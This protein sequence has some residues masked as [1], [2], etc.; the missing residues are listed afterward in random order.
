M[1]GRHTFPDVE[2]VG[3]LA[4]VLRLPAV[5]RVR[6]SG[7]KVRWSPKD[8]PPGDP[9]PPRL[10]FTREPMAVA[11]EVVPIE[12]RDGVSRAR[13]LHTIRKFIPSRVRSPQS[14]CGPRPVPLQLTAVWIRLR[15]HNCE[16]EEVLGSVTSSHPDGSDQA[17]N[18]QRLPSTKLSVV[19]PA[20]T[21]GW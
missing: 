10:R 9:H 2:M 12:K 14:R 17:V 7:P 5:H 4:G 21:L 3:T 1:G 18:R 15:G 8:P 6:I 16:N 20:R 13:L 11:D 19:T